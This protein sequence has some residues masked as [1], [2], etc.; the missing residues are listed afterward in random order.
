[1]NTVDFKPFVEWSQLSESYTITAPS[2][3]RSAIW[4]IL[5]QLQNRVIEIDRGEP[6]EIIVKSNSGYRPREALYILAVATHIAQAGDFETLYAVT[7]G[8]P[9]HLALMKQNIDFKGETGTFSV[10]EIKYWIDSWITRNSIETIKGEINSINQFSLDWIDQ[11][12]LVVTKVRNHLEEN[13]SWVFKPFLKSNRLSHC[14]RVLEYLNE[15][16]YTAEFANSSIAVL[17]KA[18]HSQLEAFQTVLE[19]QVEG[20]YQSFKDTLKYVQEYRKDAKDFFDS[21][22]TNKIIELVAE[23]SALLG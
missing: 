13:L 16:R 4:S 3:L 1:M 20:T 8:Y 9:Q 15:A 23:T 12:V 22:D 7:G 11:R 17:A 10:E 14:D 18:A 2:K 5:F 19:K 6:T 21:V